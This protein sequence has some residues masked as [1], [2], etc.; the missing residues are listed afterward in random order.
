MYDQMICVGLL[1]L[2]Y[3]FSCFFVVFYLSRPEKSLQFLLLILLFIY[4]VSFNPDIDL[5][6]VFCCFFGSFLLE[7]IKRAF[8]VL[9]AFDAYMGVNL[10]GL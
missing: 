3:I 5:Q 9:Y 8:N 6:F 1:L 4:K 7:I 10:S 2:T